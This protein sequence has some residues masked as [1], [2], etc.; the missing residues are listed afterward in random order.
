[1]KGLELKNKREELHLTQ[2]QLA[3]QVGMSRESIINY[4]KLDEIPQK[5]SVILNMYFEKK[6]KSVNSGDT[7]IE[8]TITVGEYEVTLKEYDMAF[9]QNRE[10]IL[11][12]CKITSLIIDG[13]AN[14]KFKKVLEDNNIEVEYVPKGKTTA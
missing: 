13:E 5:K 2:S 12:K 7:G 10:L 11:S 9:Y 14:K 4:E 6:L 3:E 1:M 8:E